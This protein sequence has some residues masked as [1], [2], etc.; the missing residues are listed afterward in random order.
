L[1]DATIVSNVEIRWPSG[2]IQRLSAVPA[3]QILTVQE[4]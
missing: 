4:P 3:N 1:G 2:K